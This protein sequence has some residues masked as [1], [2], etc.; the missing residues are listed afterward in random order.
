M[1]ITEPYMP[2]KLIF[3]VKIQHFVNTLSFACLM[4]T[5]ESL[6]TLLS[7]AKTIFLILKPY[8]LITFKKVGLRKRAVSFTYKNIIVYIKLRMVQSRI[9]FDFM[10]N[11]P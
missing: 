3:F 10:V 1:D 8:L 4:Y 11:Q 7:R 6:A 9:I 5:S 2:S